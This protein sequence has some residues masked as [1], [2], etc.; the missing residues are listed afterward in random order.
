VTFKDP[1]AG[2]YHDLPAAEAEHWKSKLRRHSYATFHASARSAAWKTIPS[3]YLMCEDDRALPIYTQEI[4]VK[5]CQDLGAKME[6]E[7]IFCS[8]SPFL[9]KPDETLGFL[10]RAAGE[11]V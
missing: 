6:T 1:I 5:S 7:R 2:F 8:H 11:E 10:R 9:A 3:S 4:L